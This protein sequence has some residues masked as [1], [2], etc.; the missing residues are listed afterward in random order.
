M[1]PCCIFGTPG[2]QSAYAKVCYKTEKLA[3][4]IAATRTQIIGGNYFDQPVSCITFA[5]DY[6]P[7]SLPVDFR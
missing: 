4:D 6:L 5:V 2:C 7:V 1:P 3:I